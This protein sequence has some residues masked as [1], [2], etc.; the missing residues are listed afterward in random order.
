MLMLPRNS[1]ILLDLC[2][3]H[4]YGVV[5]ADIHPYGLASENLDEEFYPG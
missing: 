5:D 1:R 3:E 2:L 4:L